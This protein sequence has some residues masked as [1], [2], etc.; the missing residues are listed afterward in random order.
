MDKKN[1]INRTQFRNRTICDLRTQGKT[2]K[3]IGNLFGISH[4]GAN[5][6]Y[7]TYTKH[8]KNSKQHTTTKEMNFRNYSESCDFLNRGQTNKW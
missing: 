6:I 3:E 2:H 1:Q 8:I 4:Q 7:D 5:Q